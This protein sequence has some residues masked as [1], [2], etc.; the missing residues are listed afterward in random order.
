MASG[1]AAESLA[2]MNLAETAGD[3][4]V[5][6]SSLYGGTYNLFHYTLPKYGIDV[7]FVTDQDDLDAWRKAITPTTKAL[8]AETI[9]NPKGDVLDLEGVAG[10]AHEAVSRSSSTTRWR[11]R[12][13]AGRSS[14]APTSSCTP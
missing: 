6:S 4:I 10:V 7:G 9:G 12:T 11:R 14:G 3:S 13:C 5:S 8:F 1:Q 2:I